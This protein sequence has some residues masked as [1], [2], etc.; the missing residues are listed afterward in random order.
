M[1]NLKKAPFLQS[2]EKNQAPSEVISIYHANTS[3]FRDFIL[4][5]S[6]MLG[7]RNET[8]K[9]E[10]EQYLE[11]YLIY[12]N[13]LSQSHQT[14]DL[15]NIYANHTKNLL[16]TS[17][18]EASP[19]IENILINLAKNLGNPIHY[20]DL[21]KSTNYYFIKIKQF[22]TSL[23]KIKLIYPI[24][25]FHQLLSTELTK[26]P[27]IYFSDPGIRNYLLNNFNR[28]PLRDDIDALLEQFTYLHIIT[29]NSPYT[30]Y[31]WQTRAKAGISFVLQKNREIIPIDIQYSPLS[32]PHIP[33]N[34]ST[35]IHRYQPYKA[36]ILTQG[37]WNMS[38]LGRTK[39]A[40]IPIWYAN[41]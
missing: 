40:F 7:T 16:I 9:S 28:L 36:I 32:K 39:I 33:R 12:G 4:T 37:Y 27:K 31:F 2:L 24:L 22:I 30:A 19:E 34:L 13:I 26:N 15:T 10:F 5:D 3:L 6:L 17:N 21:Q 35:F 8:K 41:L 20:K 25:P 11:K 23:E 38:F 29:Q 1:D 18:L 14:A